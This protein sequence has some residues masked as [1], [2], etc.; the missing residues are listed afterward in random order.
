MYYFISFF[1]FQK[2]WTMKLAYSKNTNAKITSGNLVYK[3]PPEIIKSKIFTHFNFI[4]K[5]LSAKCTNK[6]S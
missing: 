4:A 6:T 5:P 1:F 2:P 3:I